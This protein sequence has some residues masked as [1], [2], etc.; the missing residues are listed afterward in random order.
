MPRTLEHKQL[1]APARE[2]WV[3]VSD[4]YRMPEWWPR[5]ER[6]EGVSDGQF[7]QIMRSKSGRIVR[8]DFR[9]LISDASAMTLEIE[10][11]IEG[12]PFASVLSRSTARVAIEG[13]HERCEVAVELDQ[14]PASGL[15][16]IG[17]LFISRAAR[18]TA[19]E[20]LD[21]LER[22]VG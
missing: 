7:T 8:G 22:A 14:E 6:V 2:V 20:A 5:V 15:A 10:Q 21:S 3:M 4:P 9:I 11:L 19:R 1:S 12:T 16:R 18:S 13:D 17:S